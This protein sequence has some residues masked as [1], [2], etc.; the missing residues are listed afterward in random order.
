M[1]ISL[2]KFMEWQTANDGLEGAFK[3]FTSLQDCACHGGRTP[4]NSQTNVTTTRGLDG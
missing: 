4:N 2:S 3:L 1:I